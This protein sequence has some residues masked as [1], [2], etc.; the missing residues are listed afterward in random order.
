VEPLARLGTWGVRVR[1]PEGVEAHGVE[2]G[3]GGLFLHCAE[4]FPPL[5]TRLSL[6]LWLGGEEVPCEGEVVRH[7]DAAHARVWEVS[8]GI[9]VQLVSPCPRLRE[10]FERVRG[11][12][13]ASVGAPGLSGR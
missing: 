6:T 1:H 7:V 12:S 4:P 13:S 11:Q 8:P 2:L 5:F 3:R 10:L 9:G